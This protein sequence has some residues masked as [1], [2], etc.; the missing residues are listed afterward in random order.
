MTLP[1]SRRLGW[2]VA[3]RISMI[4]VAFSSTTLCATMFPYWPSAI[5]SR[6]P[7]AR[8]ANRFSVSFVLGGCSSWTGTRAMAEAM[9]AGERPAADRR[10]ASAARDRAD[11]TFGGIAV[12]DHGRRCGR[13]P[14][15]EHVE[16]ARR[17]LRLPGRD[18][19]DV[20]DRHVRTQGRGSR[21]EAPARAPAIRR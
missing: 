18:V 11:S 8:L 2:I 20:A 4:R 1:A 7:R 10:A 5:Q 17:H 21:G 9:A 19:G 3:S 14:R 12:F 13:R 16:R 15:H 6:M